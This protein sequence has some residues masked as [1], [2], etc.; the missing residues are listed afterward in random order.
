[1]IHT[2]LAL[3][4]CLCLTCRLSVSASAA[5]RRSS[6]IL[7]IF[8]FLLGPPRGPV[9]TRDC[10]SFLSSHPLGAFLILPPFDLLQHTHRTTEEAF[11]SAASRMW[12]LSVS[13]S[14]SFSSRS[15]SRFSATQ[16]RVFVFPSRALQRDAEGEREQPSRT[17]GLLFFHSSPLVFALQ[18]AGGVGQDPVSSSESQGVRMCSSPHAA[19]EPWIPGGR[20]WGRRTRLRCNSAGLAALSHRLHAPT[21]AP[22]VFGEVPEMLSIQAYL[23]VYLCTYVPMLPCGHSN[24]APTPTLVSLYDDADLDRAETQSGDGVL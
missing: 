7:G 17:G 15:L 12:S 4:V 18:D 13:V 9:H 14:L 3:S 20:K 6:F 21:E 2:Y 22:H 16:A 23:Y 11:S 24:A 5:K 1:M 10:L 8:P 19:E